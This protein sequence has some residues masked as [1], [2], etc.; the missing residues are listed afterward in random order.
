[1]HT[2][3]HTWEAKEASLQGCSSPIRHEPPV[4]AAAPQ[5]AKRVYPC[6][7]YVS[8]SVSVSPTRRILH[9]ATNNGFEF[10]REKSR[11]LR[12]AGQVSGSALSRRALRS[13]PCRTP[14][15]RS[16]TPATGA[17]PSRSCAAT[18]STARYVLPHWRRTSSEHGVSGRAPRVTL[19]H[20]TTSRVRSAGRTQSGRT[21]RRPRAKPA[22]HGAS[23]GARRYQAR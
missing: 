6:P 3:M 4:R 17:A 10:V 23:R 1:V 11:V 18:A 5:A 22:A 13:P 14:R 8:P 15:F 9:N 2:L 12:N 7:G 21:S 20:R 16:T 19:I